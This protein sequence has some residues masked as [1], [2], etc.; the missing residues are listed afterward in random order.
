[1]PP[2]SP[3]AQDDEEEV[4]KEVPMRRMRRGCRRGSGT[5][6]REAK[7]KKKKDEVVVEDRPWLEGLSEEEEE[8]R[9]KCNVPP[10]TAMSSLWAH[11]N[12]NIILMQG[13]S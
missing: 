3:S 7:K 11:C 12:H 9:E 8:M 5:I 1:M 4:K 10:F 13:V 6:R 2:R